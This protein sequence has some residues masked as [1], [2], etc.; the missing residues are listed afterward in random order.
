MRE[1]AAEQYLSYKLID[2]N[3][4]L[5]AKWF[6]VTNHHPELPKP[7]GQQPKH[8]PWWNTEPTMQEG[9]QLPELLQKIKALREAGLRAEHVAFSIMKR[10]VQLLMARDTLGYQYTGDDDTSRMPGNEVDVEDIVERLGRIFKDMPPYTPC[11]VPEY[12]AARRTLSSSTDCIVVVV[13]TQA[14]CCRMTLLSLS[15]IQLLLLDL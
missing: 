8:R 2:S 15:S 4:D 11:P 3:Q 6:Y 13:L 1:D 9:I 14:V 7:T 12:S 5:K 10:R